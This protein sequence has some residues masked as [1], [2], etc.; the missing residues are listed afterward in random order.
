[1]EI[2]LTVTELWSVQELF[3]DG[4]TDSVMPKYVRVFRTGVKKSGSMYI[5]WIVLEGGDHL[6][7]TAEILYI[8]KQEGYEAL[9]HS[10]EQTS[11]E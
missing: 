11:F 4:Q 10:S 8:M 9:N 5:F 2:T 6:L 7:I 1:M 3:T